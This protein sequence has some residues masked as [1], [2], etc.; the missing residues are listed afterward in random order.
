M[1]AVHHTGTR[2]NVNND[3]A[4][5]RLQALLQHAP[6]T[7]PRPGAPVAPAASVPGVFSPPGRGAQA[8]L[9]LSSGPWDGRGTH[10]PQAPRASGR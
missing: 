3:E 10:P 1:A 2:A 9:P 5:R 6:Y 4:H 8:S 7:A